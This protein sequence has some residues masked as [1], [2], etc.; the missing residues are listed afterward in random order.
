MGDLI[1][2]AFF[3]I[4]NAFVKAMKIFQ[5][6][7]WRAALNRTSLRRNSPADDAII[8]RLASGGMMVWV[9]LIIL[10][11]ISFGMGW[12]VDTEGSG[13]ALLML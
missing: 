1:M 7:K 9:V 6:Q 5:F 11:S 3:K 12:F 10:F 8:D 13:C 4:M 2:S